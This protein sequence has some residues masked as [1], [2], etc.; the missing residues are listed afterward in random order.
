MFSGCKKYFGMGLGA[1]GLLAPVQAEAVTIT[2]NVGP[3]KEINNNL[4]NGNP[5]TIFDF[6]QFQLGEHIILDVTFDL[7]VASNLVDLNPLAGEGRF[8]DPNGTFRLTGSVTGTSL[9]LSPGVELE[10]NSDR[11]L[12]FESPHSEPTAGIPLIIDDDVDF[13]F[14]FGV[15]SNPD[16]LLVSIDDLFASLPLVNVGSS[17]SDADV[18]FFDG[19]SFGT[20]GI[21]YGPA[22]S[23][24]PLPA[25]LPLL[26]T[27]L[28]VFGFVRRRRA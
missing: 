20:N 23:I 26:L 3:I 1:L 5:N 21:K 28:A 25:T 17:G 13:D 19:D 24:V 15:F 22:V 10:F 7:S 2:A 14:A 6:T 16:D 11:A 18:E 4:P 27:G 9:T 12:D 8:V